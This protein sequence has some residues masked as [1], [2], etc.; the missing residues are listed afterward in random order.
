MHVC[1]HVI[2]MQVHC[3]PVIDGVHGFL[4][5]MSSHPLPRRSLM[6]LCERLGLTRDGVPEMSI[7][8]IRYVVLELLPRPLQRRAG[9]KTRDH[10]AVL[11][12]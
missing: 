11:A 12:A 6:F 1:K 7:L 3:R 5:S 8:L 10:R 2:N 4:I 9:Q